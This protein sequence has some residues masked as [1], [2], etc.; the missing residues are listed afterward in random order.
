LPGKKEVT[1]SEDEATHTQTQHALV[2]AWGEFAQRLGLIQGLEAVDLH[3]KRYQHTPQ[4]KMIEFLVATLAGLEHLKDISRA[5]HPLDQD[6]TLARAWGQAAWAD[7][8]G[9]SRSLRSLTMRE[10]EQ[11][12]QVLE[13]SSQ[14]FI[15]SEINLAVLIEKRLVYDGDLTGLAVSKGSTTYP[16]VAFGHMDDQI[17]LGYQAAVVSL[18]SPGGGRIW[19]S[20][21][22]HPGNLV[23]AVAAEGMILAAEKRTGVRP[24]R[25]TEL[26]EQRLQAVQQAGQT[27]RQKRLDRVQKVQLAHQALEEASQVVTEWQA[28]VEDLAAQYHSRQR[29]ERPTGELASAR[30]KLVSLQKRVERRQ[31]ACAKAEQVLAWTDGLLEEQSAE[32]QRLQQRL[33]QFEQDNRS[34]PQPVPAVFRLDAG[35]GTYTNL[36][37]LIEMGYE[38]YTKLQNW[39]VLQCLCKQVPT[40]ARWTEVDHQVDMWAWAQHSLENFC[41][42]I[43]IGLERFTDED[44][45]TYCALLHFGDTPVTRDLPQW[46]GFYAGRQTIEAGIKESKQVFFLH[47]L[48]VRSQAAIYLQENFVLFAANFIRWANTWL[49]TDRNDHR[50]PVERLGIKDLV[51]VAAHTSADV[52]WNSDV[53]LLKFSQQSVFAGKVLFLPDFA[54]QLPLPL[55]KSF[56]FCDVSTV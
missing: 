1:M 4:T 38:V 35:F 5:A 13:A 10:A 53:K 27:L 30:N 23:S 19:L 18:R 6:R 36:A 55:A 9:V 42:P 7:Y 25:R 26:L 45:I 32:E 51:R 48:K 28:R 47:R 14:M 24:R 37:L 39:R 52:V 44:H 54:F 43:D 49:A 29:A 31:K 46:F 16:G 41:Y 12:V 22:H 2:A 17:R 11:I 34:N 3:Q 56:D 21:E 20:V 15:T 50:L 40:D 8:S 33:T